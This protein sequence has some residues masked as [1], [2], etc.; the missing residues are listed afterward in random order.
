MLKKFLKKKIYNF[1]GPH[2]KHEID[3]FRKHNKKLKTGRFARNDIDIILEKLL[4]HRDGYYVE[5]GAHDGALASN[6][7][8]FEL[9]KNWRG[10]LIEP[11]PNLFLKCLKRRSEDNQIYCNACV[12]FEYDK[13]YVD[14]IYSDSTTISNNLDLDIKD[15]EQHTK[16]VPEKEQNFIFGAKSATLNSLLLKSN[17]PKLI[18]F[19]S[20]DV[21]GAELDV[22]KGIDFKMYNFKYMIIESR[23]IERTQKYLKN[24]DYDL[25]KEISAYDY[26][27]SFNKKY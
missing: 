15:I 20:L 18:D 9:K 4:P 1:L 7:Y 26:L 17:S 13:K 2:L 3:V 19:L 25:K 8:Y 21:E 12:S 22:L 24:Y 27:F 16:H 5:L 23:N 14:M 11:S 6:S 10:I